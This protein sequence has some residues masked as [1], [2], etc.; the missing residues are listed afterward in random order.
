MMHKWLAAALEAS[1]ISQ[2]ELARRM[3]DDLRRAYDRVMV[4]RM[5]RENG[6]KISGDEMLAISMITGHPIPEDATPKSRPPTGFASPPIHFPPSSLTERAFTE[7]I[8][9]ESMELLVAAGVLEGKAP[10]AA[11]DMLIA[12]CVMAKSRE[13][14]G[15]GG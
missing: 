2:A 13:P 4:N 12:A 5:L 11:A 3:T 10:S 14:G 15:S 8:V 1:G 6:R 7:H 9:R